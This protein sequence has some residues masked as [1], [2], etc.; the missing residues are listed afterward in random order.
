MKKGQ[1]IFQHRPKNGCMVSVLHSIVSLESKSFFA[2]KEACAIVYFLRS[3]TKADPVAALN[4]LQC[5]F[6]DGCIFP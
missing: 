5:C 3:E 6:M 2:R 4:S 1:V